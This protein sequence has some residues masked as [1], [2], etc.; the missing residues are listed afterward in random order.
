[1][2]KSN[3]LKIIV[4]GIRG[5]PNIPGGI[6]KHCEKLYP[7]LVKKGFS[8]TV[9]GRSPYIGNKR[10]YYEG[11]KVVPLWCPK[12]KFTE[13]LVHTFIATALSV[14]HPRAILHYHALGPSF[15]IL[16]ARLFRKKIVAT[17]H[18]FDYDRI[19]WG[20]FARMFIKTGE[21]QLCRANR[22]IS[23]SRHISD[24]LSSH[25]KCDSVLIPNGVDIPNIIPPGAYCQKW[26]ITRK[27]Y[28]LFAGRLVPEKGV[29]V[30]LDAF[31]MIPSDWKICIAGDTDHEDTYSKKLKKR[32]AQ[33]PDVIMTGYISGTELEELYSNAGAFILPSSH[34]GLPIALLEALSYGLPCI[35]SDIPANRAVPFTPL[36]FFPLN[37]TET[38]ASIMRAVEKGD[39]KWKHESARQFVRENYNWD[40]IA[41][42]TRKAFLDII[43]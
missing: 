11:V 2:K 31:E 14:L 26:N 25:Y 5:I 8:V 6:E 10:Y 16:F 3:R 30:L 17:H 42:K 1:M 35:A 15:F 28:F 27:K 24:K 33:T 12:N 4:L 7:R 29:H 18:G 37:D 23:I 34:E 9:F 32:G 39:I 19:K 40:D 13:A 21:R 41:E 22:V 36:L 20:T 43:R 38:L